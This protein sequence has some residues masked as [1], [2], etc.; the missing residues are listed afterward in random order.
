V[1]RAPSSLTAAFQPGS[2]GT[3]PSSSAAM[4]LARIVRAEPRLLCRSTSS[5]RGNACH[6]ARSVAQLIQ[7]HVPYGAAPG[8]RCRVV[9]YLHKAPC[10]SRTRSGR[11]T[12]YLAA[13]H[14]PRVMDLDLR[15]AGRR[16]HDNPVP[17]LIARVRFPS[18]FPRSP[19]G[20]GPSQRR[21]REPRCSRTGESLFVPNAILVVYSRHAG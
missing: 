9:R 5:P 12:R 19:G 4:T 21:G 10:P 16:G 11:C 3:D 6:S 18:P 7:I 8:K 17:K 2:G 20:D 15:T 13:T 14:G 1:T